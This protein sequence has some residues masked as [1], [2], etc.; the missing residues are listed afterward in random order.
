[1]DVDGDSR[2]QLTRDGK[3]GGPTYSWISATRT[4]RR[5]AVIRAF[6][7]QVLD[8]R[9]R[10]L[11]KPLP[12]SGT[13][14]VAQIAPDG[15]RV[16]TLEQIGELLPPPPGTIDP[17]L[18]TIRP[19][20]F[21]TRPDGGDKQ[22]VARAVTTTAWLGSGLLRSEVSEDPPFASGI[23]LLASPLEFPCARDVAVDSQSD[24][25]SAAASPNGRLL[26]VTASPAES[27]AAD[28]PGRIVLFD[29][30]TA[31]RIRTLTQGPDDTLPSWSP[32]G[33]R[34]AFNRG[35]SIYV[36]R[37]NGKGR[38]RRIARNAVQPVWV[39]GG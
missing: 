24:L 34:I 13:A 39:A 36:V 19:Y 25:S 26:A 12:R 10:K 6:Y 18:L 9:G 8:S 3:P 1:M 32:D 38:P 20:M 21:S 15:R 28:P 27:E 17:P 4:G 16:V 23:C 30:R 7:A 35:R 33:K 14:L 2:R 29:T 11:G 31:A 37:A 22:T 5:L